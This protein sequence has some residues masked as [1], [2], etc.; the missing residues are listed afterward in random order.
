MNKSAIYHLLCKLSI[1]I[2]VFI[3]TGNLAIASNASQNKNNF[4]R[5]DWV[6]CTGIN[7]FIVK[8]NQKVPIHIDKILSNQIA[9]DSLRALNFGLRLYNTETQ[10]KASK[11]W[12]VGELTT[13]EYSDPAT[14]EKAYVFILH[15]WFL[16]TPFVGAKW[17]ETLDLPSG[18]YYIQA[19]ERKLLKTSDFEDWLIKKYRK[20]DPELYI[21]KR[22]D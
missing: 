1:L 6:E 18:G 16:E 17:V 15:H 20:F 11:I 19:G 2:I 7:H 12:V 3:I 5:F 4:F 10:S 13:T 9:W 14:K 8:D 22:N 21:K